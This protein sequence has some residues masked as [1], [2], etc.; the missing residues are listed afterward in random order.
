VNVHDSRIVEWGYEGIYAYDVDSLD[1]LRSEVSLNRSEGI[2]AWASSRPSISVRL[3]QSRLEK[4][5]WDA[6]YV[7]GGARTVALDHNFIYPVDG[8][9]IY[10]RGA[11]DPL[12]AAAGVTMTM[13]GDSIKFR[14]DDYNWIWV[15]NMDSVAIDSLWY[16]NPADTAMWQYGR[17]DANVLTLTNSQL[18]NLWEEGIDFSGRRL[19]VDNTT[20]TGCQDPVDCDWFD[21]LAIDATAGNDSGPAV[22]LTNST[23][24]NVYYALRATRTQDSAGPMFIQ[25][26]VVDSAYY[27][28]DVAGDSLVITD[29]VITRLYQEGIATTRSGTN[30]PPE[31]ATIA[32]NRISCVD[33]ATGYAINHL[34]A[35]GRIEHNTID[36]C[37]YGIY[38]WNSTSYPLQTLM[39]VGDTINLPPGGPAWNG[40]DLEGRWLATVSHN[41]IRDAGQFGIYLRPDINPG[42]LAA[43]TMDSNAVSNAGNM[44][45]YINPIDSID[46]VGRWNNIAGSTFDGILNGGVGLR[47]FTL[48]RFVGNGRWA[49][50]S[51][52]VFNATQNWWGDPGGAGIPGV[53]DSVT[54]NVDASSPLL[55]DPTGVTVPLP[56]PHFAAL[57][58]RLL[59][60]STLGAQEPGDHLPV[61]VDERARQGRR[62]AKELAFKQRSAA[63]DAERERR[64]QE[65]ERVRREHMRGRKVRM[66][67]LPE[68]R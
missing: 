20:F 64:V 15:T 53:S 33:G 11:T 34:H 37:G 4:N 45:I 47:S 28:I 21:V 31:L 62:T 56:S 67:P 24:W 10:V 43:I 30:K 60:S 52:S 61:S 51:S 63:R 29:N 25:N 39:V 57:G 2:Y 41:R 54:A 59:R 42:D 44:G 18:L 36:N 26:N 27:G 35:P 50:N 5:R 32:R 1:V 66:R 65:S 48:G 55:T 13:L 22:T 68:P 7:G 17:I 23:F 3:S 19:V 16:E 6:L 8:D 12:G 14:A 46:V 58:A 9:A 38:A 49:I 40:I